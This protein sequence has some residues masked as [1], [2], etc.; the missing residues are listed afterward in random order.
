MPDRSAIITYPFPIGRATGGARM[1]RE[2]AAGLGRAGVRVRIVTVSSDLSAGRPRRAAA[3]EHLGHEF[4]EELAAVGV[5]VHR[6][7]P[8]R[9]HW[10]LDGL[11]VKR[12]VVRLLREEPAD[13]VL[14]YHHEGAFLVKVCAEAG[15]R[16]GIIATWQSYAAFLDAKLAPG[17]LD[18]MANERLIR[19][20][21]RSADVLFATSRYTRGELVDAVGVAPERVRLMPLGV[22]EDFFSIPR[23]REDR[24][25]RLLFFGRVIESKGV[26]DLLEALARVQR[27]GVD[28]WT[29]RVVGLGRHEAVRDAARR[30]GIADRVEVR[31]AVDD[32]GLRHELERAQLVALPSHFEAFGLAFA[33]A[34]AAALP[35]VAYRAG[36]VPEVVQDGTTGWLAPLRDID[37][38]TACLQQALTD[39][40]ATQAAGRA[41]RER[42]QREFTWQRTATVVLDGIEAVCG[43]SV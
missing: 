32:Q 13:I 34:Q 33:E 37:G 35:V 29:L 12:A 10:L 20:P 15:A 27:D 2:I 38:L 39:A 21:F 28:H 41:A 1:T 4:D 26:F 18:G 22:R 23:E 16:R 7:D 17:P 5:T 3:A 14:S 30:L 31:D 25:E 42:M 43:V 6:V 19:R 40:A 11:P 36:S 9:W 8:H 24:I